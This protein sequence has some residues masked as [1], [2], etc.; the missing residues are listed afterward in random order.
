MILKSKNIFGL[1]LAFC[2]MSSFSLDVNAG[3]TQRKPH[4]AFFQIKLSPQEAF[5]IRISENLSLRS[6]MAIPQFGVHVGRFA[7]TLGLEYLHGSTYH[8]RESRG[9]DPVEEERL[10][11]RA[12]APEIGARISLL[13]HNARR[14]E[15]YLF[16]GIFRY[17]SSADFWHDEY[18]EVNIQRTEDWLEELTSPWGYDVSFGAE[19]RLDDWLAIGAEVGIRGYRFSASYEAV[20]TSPPFWATYKEVERLSAAASTALITFTFGL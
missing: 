9:D 20:F 7:I 11:I 18:E 16:A 13:G 12:F 1:L 8:K 17:F 19:Y 3:E 15:V 5:D 6:T 4:R 10:R 14:T 2:L